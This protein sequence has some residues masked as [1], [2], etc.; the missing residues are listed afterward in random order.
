M[1]ANGD[2]RDPAPS[3]EAPQAPPVI[4]ATLLRRGDQVLEVWRP[5][6]PMPGEEDEYVFG[7]ACRAADARAGE[8]VTVLLELPTQDANEAFDMLPAAMRQARQQAEEKLAERVRSKILR[9]SAGVG[10]KHLQRE[11]KRK[12]KRKRR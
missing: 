10:V 2:L 7:Y 9:A 4:A 5:F 3:E 1:E 8:S 11:G 6:A 12:G